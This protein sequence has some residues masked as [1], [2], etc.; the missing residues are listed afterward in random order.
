[1]TDAV[2]IIPTYNE[3]ENIEAIINAVFAQPNTFDVLIV[4][5]NSP[6]GTGKKV[7]EMQAIYPERLFLLSREEKSG[8]GTAYI[9][10]FKWCL[11]KKYQYIFE[12]DADFSHNPEDLN[13]LYKTCKTDNVDLAIGCLLYTSDAADE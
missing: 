10:G 4:D 3:I 1:M 5:D 8:L 2:V 12:M 13:K 6:D 9:S 7:K 11:E